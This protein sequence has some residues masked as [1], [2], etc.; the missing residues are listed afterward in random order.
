MEGVPAKLPASSVG[1][2][3]LDV[4]VIHMDRISNEELMKMSRDSAPDPLGALLP[5]QPGILPERE[6][7]LTGLPSSLSCIRRAML[8]CRSSSMHSS[9]CDRKQAECSLIFFKMNLALI[10]VQGTSR[11]GDP[12]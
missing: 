11:Q 1:S 3:A 4:T 12:E 6:A 2:A 10:N 8:F 5:N 7:H 9:P